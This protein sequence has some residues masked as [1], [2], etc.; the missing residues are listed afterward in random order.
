MFGYV[1][2]NQQ[3][4]KY[5]E[6]DLYHSYYCGF[7]RELK[8]RYGF[9][10]QLTLSYDMTFLILLLSSLYETEG[11]TG[12]TKCVAHPFEQ[13]ETRTNFYTE[14]A[15]D[16][17]LILS[18]Y[19]CMDDWN[20]ERRLHKLALG[21]L[22]EKSQGKAALSYGKKAALIKDRLDRL[23]TSEQNKDADIDK[24]A[25]YFG[26]IMAEIFA[27]N[28]DEWESDLRQVGFFLGKFIYIMDAYEDMEKDEKSGSYN[29]LLLIRGSMS[30]GDSDFENYCH[31]ILTMM[32]ARCCESFETLPILDN[33]TI[34]RNILYSGVWTRW[35]TLHK[36]ADKEK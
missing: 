8:K 7:C 17:N 29:P 32:I 26:D 11:K 22:I 21:K 3:E 10:G 5:R 18:Y 16:I 20:D 35:E 15:A 2:P 13:H 1:V 28:E 19:S 34:L 4:L 27:V 14:Y 25:G 24:V 6:Y 31:E 36:P 30:S 23:H 12:Q 9:L 33:I